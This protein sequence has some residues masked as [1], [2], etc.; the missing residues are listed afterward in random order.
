MPDGTELAYAWVSGNPKTK[1]SMAARPGRRCRCCSN[2]K[3]HLGT[4][5][6]MESVVG[7]KEWRSM[8]SE[9]LHRAMLS[10]GSQV[11]HVGKVTVAATFY[12]DVENVCDSG[13]GDLDKLCRNALDAAT[14]AKVYGDDVMVVRMVVDKIGRDEEWPPGI[15]PGVALILWAGRVR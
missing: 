6:M 5:G 1:G 8:M 2:C 4:T 10:M 15:A 3:G 7:S 9:G 11:S 12:L 14:D 13:A